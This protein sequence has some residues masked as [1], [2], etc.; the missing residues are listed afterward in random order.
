MVYFILLVLGAFLIAMGFR[1][2]I[3]NHEITEIVD[4]AAYGK[5]QEAVWHEMGGFNLLFLQFGPNMALS[6]LAGAGVLAAYLGLWMCAL[7][8]LSGLLMVILGAAVC[9]VIQYTMV[10]RIKAYFA[11][12]EKE[13]G[14]DPR[15]YFTGKNGVPHAVYTSVMVGVGKVVKFVLIVS[16]VGILLYVILKRAVLKGLDL[17]ATAIRGDYQ[18]PPKRIYDENE[19]AWFCTDALG[20]DGNIKVYSPAPGGRTN[21]SIRVY[22]DSKQVLEELEKHPK[23]TRIKVGDRIFHWEE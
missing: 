6:F 2:N 8:K 23:A 17:E 10:A 1:A 5:E 22:I 21:R 3:L 12:Y 14:E 9:G 4:A 7:G 20:E 13:M 19:D 16:V 11:G 15:P 18:F